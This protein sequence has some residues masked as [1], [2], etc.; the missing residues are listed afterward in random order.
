MFLNHLHNHTYQL[1][2]NPINSL[3]SNNSN[4][5]SIN[6][7][8]SI[9]HPLHN[10]TTDIN[11]ISSNN[12]SDNRSHLYINNNLY[13]NSSNLYI[14]SGNSRYLSNLQCTLLDKFLLSRCI[15]L[16]LLQQLPL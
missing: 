15:N 12:L 11:N 2:I 10:H 14:Q 13:I 9:L 6:N 4:H 5:H 16:F 3:F 1:L 8:S 7:N